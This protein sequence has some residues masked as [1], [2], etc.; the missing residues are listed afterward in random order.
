MKS[1]KMLGLLS[2]CF[3]MIG[4]GAFFLTACG[5]NNNPEPPPSD[6][7][8]S[9]ISVSIAP[10]THTLTTLGSTIQLTANVIVVGGAEQTVTWT[11]SNSAVAT[12]SS[13]GLVTAIKNG[14]VTI[15][16]TSTVNNARTGMATVTVDAYVPSG[17]NGNGQNNDNPIQLVTPIINFGADGYLNWQS[18]VP[19]ATSIRV[20]VGGTEEFNG[21]IAPNRL[22]LANILRARGSGDWIITAQFLGSENVVNSATA[23]LVISVRQFSPVIDLSISGVNDQTLNWLI[24]GGNMVQV[25]SIGNVTPHFYTVYVNGISRGTTSDLSSVQQ[26]NL[27]TG[28]SPSVQ[29]GDMLRIR[30]QER[31][32]PNFALLLESAQ[33]EQIERTRQLADINWSSFNQNL[34]VIS[35]AE[36]PSAV[37]YRLYFRRQGANAFATIIETNTNSFDLRPLMDSSLDYTADFENFTYQIFIR[38]LADTATGSGWRDPQFSTGHW[39]LIRLPVQ[40]P[41]PQFWFNMRGTYITWTSSALAN[42]YEVEILQGT[43]TVTTIATFTTTE[44]YFEATSID[45]GERTGT[46]RLRVRAISDNDIVLNSGWSE[47]TFTRLNAPTPPPSLV[48]WNRIQIAPVSGDVS[49][50]GLYI[51]GERRIL[52]TET[53]RE[54]DFLQ[55]GLP[56][57]SH[58]VQLRAIARTGTLSTILDSPL[59]NATIFTILPQQIATPQNLQV[60]DTGV[61]SWDS[62]PNAIGYRIDAHIVREPWFWSSELLTETSICL[63]ELIALMGEDIIFNHNDSFR[64]VAVGTPYG[65]FVRN[66]AFSAQLRIN[67]TMTPTFEIADGILTITGFVGSTLNFPNHGNAFAFRVYLTNEALGISETAYIDV[68]SI[69]SNGFYTHTQFPVVASLVSLFGELAEATGYVVNVRSI[70]DTELTGHGTI[71]LDSNRGTPITITIGEP[72]PEVIELT[73]PTGVSVSIPN[74]IL[75]WSAV[76]NAQMYQ[77]RI[78]ELNGTLVREISTSATSI[79]LIPSQQLNI[80]LPGQ[81]RFSVRAVAWVDGE[82]LT[83]E[84]SAQHTGIVQRQH[85]RPMNVEIDNMYVNWI[86]PPLANSDLNLRY[87]VRVFVVDGLSLEET[88]IGT[89]TTTQ[90][91]FNWAGQ[92]FDVPAGDTINLAFEVRVVG[93]SF[94][95]ESEPSIIWVHSGFIL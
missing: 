92:N 4:F 69:Q 47:A 33:S 12:V 14:E 27:V 30:A 52:I 74:R 28:I 10:V 16:A 81:F 65:N 9:V 18:S 34:S 87:S 79:S 73:T 89:F 29:F 11:S 86:A 36:V 17:G 38:A 62:V 55:F 25:P 2:V 58:N 41:N 48:S 6:V 8:P 44:Q 39:N 91:R 37:G 15:T 90:A 70:A 78:T 23:N 40:L 49:A 57:G 24:D 21:V 66:E 64:V 68:G 19:Y 56:V 88:E 71:F 50:I 26:L 13:A 46:F 67:Q 22:N 1:M 53:V 54:I 51:N 45:L 32:I 7:I 94:W 85:N 95:I 63:F 93:N 43:V 83:S 60:S 20:T 61:L 42:Y 35:W 5:G 3:V 75:T 72:A 31:I 82:L 77:V 84:W 76:D 59:S 80:F